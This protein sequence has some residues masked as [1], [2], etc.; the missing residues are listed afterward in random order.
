MLTHVTKGGREGGG[1]RNRISGT[2]GRSREGGREGG[3]VPSPILVE[4]GALAV[5]SAV[6]EMSD[7]NVSG[8][9]TLSALSAFLVGLQRGRADGR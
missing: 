2:H 7:V 8:R 9:V 3:D 6:F 5:P 1:G 4:E